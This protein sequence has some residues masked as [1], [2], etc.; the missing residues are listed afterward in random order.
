MLA[1][2]RSSAFLAMALDSLVRADDT[3]QTLLAL[4]SHAV[5]LANLRILALLALALDALVGA[6]T[7]WTTLAP[8]VNVQDLR[9]KIRR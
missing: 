4:A 7:C 6:Y 9:T 5:M 3:A 8:D 1:Y 2:L